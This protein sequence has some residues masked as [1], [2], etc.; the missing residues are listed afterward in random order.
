M[1]VYRGK[2]VLRGLREITPEMEKDL[3]LAYGIC[4]SYKDGFPCEMCG[5]CC[6]QPNIVVRPEEVDP[7]ARA[8]GIPLQEFISDYIIRT[9]DGRLLFSKTDP[10]VFLGGDNRCK[11]WKDRPEICRDFPYA[12]AMFMSRVYIALTD[13]SADIIELIE[14]MDDTWPCTKV[15]RSSISEKI[16]E[17]R[18]ARCGSRDTP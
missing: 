10:C 16:E 5:R 13:E 15:I 4:M 1:A 12:V 8:A 17:A 6:H 9:S 14:Y 11:V 3:D 7:L 2:Y 18:A